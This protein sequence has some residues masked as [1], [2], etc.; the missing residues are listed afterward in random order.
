MIEIQGQV[1]AVMGNWFAENRVSSD[2][3]IDSSD[4]KVNGWR[5]RSFHTAK[6]ERLFAACNRVKAFAFLNIVL[7]RDGLMPVPCGSLLTVNR[8]AKN[9]A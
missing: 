5:C 6:A 9:R 4:D 8:T 1:A 3:L 2:L 7:I